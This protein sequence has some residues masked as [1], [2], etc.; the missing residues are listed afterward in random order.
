MKLEDLKLLMNTMEGQKEVVNYIGNLE[1]R[2]E[3]FKRQE[4][5]HDSVLNELSDKLEKCRGAEYDTRAV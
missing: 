3:Y 2:I 5:H 1:E 4:I